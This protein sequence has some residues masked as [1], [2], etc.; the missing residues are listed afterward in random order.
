MRRLANPRPMRRATS[1]WRVI[2]AGGSTGAPQDLSCRWTFPRTILAHA[3]PSRL[4][5]P[6]PPYPV[7]PLLLRRAFE[8]LFDAPDQ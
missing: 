3:F 8:K 7:H 1:R 6:E 2:S 5:Q 4:T